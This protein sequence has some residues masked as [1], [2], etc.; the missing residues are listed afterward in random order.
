MARRRIKARF[1]SKPTAEKILRTLLHYSIGLLIN[2]LIFYA[3]IKTFTIAFTFSYEVF[4]DGCKNPGAT[5]VEVV[6]I[7]PDS[8]SSDIADELYD[9]GIIENKY[10]MIAKMKIGSYGGKIKAGKYGLS[11]SMNYSE[12]LDTISGLNSSDDEDEED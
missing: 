6:T 1:R 5:S 4:G 12:I 8:S 3:F 10:V 9:K 11:A 7:L 2:I